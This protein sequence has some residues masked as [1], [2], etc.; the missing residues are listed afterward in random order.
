MARIK[1]ITLYGPALVVHLD[2]LHIRGQCN[3]E[4]LQK[5]P[6]MFLCHFEG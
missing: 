5:Y 3:T 1:D 2:G 6:P 4:V